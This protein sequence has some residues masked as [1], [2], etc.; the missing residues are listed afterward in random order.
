MDDFVRNS[1]G[2]SNPAQ[3]Q[4]VQPAAS[5]TSAQAA[6]TEQA[7]P[8]EQAVTETAEQK[9]HN[10][11]TARTALKRLNAELDKKNEQFAA[12]KAEIPALRQKVRAMSILVEQLEKQ[13]AEKKVHDALRQKSKHMTGNQVMAALDLIQQLDGDLET[14]DIGELASAIRALQKKQNTEESQC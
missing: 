2:F 5:G 13:E 14:M 8:K 4:T 6:Q 12:L 10:L 1:A 3:E 7:E 9:P 11:K